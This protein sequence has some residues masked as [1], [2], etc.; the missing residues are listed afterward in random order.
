MWEV[1]GKRGKKTYSTASAA[2]LVL[3]GSLGTALGAG[4]VVEVDERVHFLFLI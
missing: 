3:V 2:G 4:L 1:K